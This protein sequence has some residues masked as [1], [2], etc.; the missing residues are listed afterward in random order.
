[1]LQDGKVVRLALMSALAVSM[2]ACAEQG[3]RDTSTASIPVATDVATERWLTG[4][5]QREFY[6]T[7]IGDSG[8][9]SGDVVCEI[10]EDGTYKLVWSTH[11]VAGSSRAGRMEMRGAAKPSS[12]GAVLDDSTGVRFTL[13][14]SGNRMYG[15]WRDPAGRRANVQVELTKVLTPGPVQQ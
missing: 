3:T 9:V 10:T 7:G 11:L 14:R 8:L 4:T 15:I 12:N 5:W 13:Q 2:A 1:M 6:Q